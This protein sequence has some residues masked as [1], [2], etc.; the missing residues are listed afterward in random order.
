M[1]TARVLLDDVVDQAFEE[2]LTNKDGH[3]KIMVTPKSA[4]L[5]ELV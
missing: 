3:L 4:N 5:R 2:L 1:V